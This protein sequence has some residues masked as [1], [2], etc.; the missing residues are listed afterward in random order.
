M[1]N[2]QKSLKLLLTWISLKFS[3][4]ASVAAPVVKNTH[5][6]VG[7]CFVFLKKSSLDQTLK[8]FNSKFGPKWIDQKSS[9]QVRQI[10]ICSYKLVPLILGSNYLKA[11][12]VSTIIKQVNFKEAWG[13]SEAKSC[14]QIQ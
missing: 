4:I 11:F 9:Y 7:I 3:K 8:T 5:I 13:E 6:L 12:R 14:L 10:S 2:H 1:L